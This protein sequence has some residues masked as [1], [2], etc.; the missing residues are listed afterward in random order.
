MSRAESATHARVV[1]TWDETPGLR[2]LALAAPHLVDQH[3]RPGQYVR[4]VSNGIEGFFALA[5]APGE[6]ELQLLV[7]RG[8]PMPDR[9]G[10][11]GPG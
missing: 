8:A 2:A 9:D 10:R 1:R 7:K 3:T 5:N 11:P 4:V 6:R